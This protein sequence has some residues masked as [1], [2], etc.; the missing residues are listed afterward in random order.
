MEPKIIIKLSE[1]F[2]FSHE[3]ARSMRREFRVHF[4]Q[5]I[6]SLSAY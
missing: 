4:N 2:E 6:I 3:I 1:V 5:L